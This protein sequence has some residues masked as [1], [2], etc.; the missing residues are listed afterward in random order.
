MAWAVVFLGSAVQA[1]EKYVTPWFQFDMATGWGQVD[2][3]KDLPSV[4][5]PSYSGFQ[6]QIDILFGS[7][8]K[9][10]QQYA[11]EK[12]Q[13]FDSDAP[14]HTVTAQRFFNTNFGYPAHEYYITYK[15][16]RFRYIDVMVEYEGENFL[17]SFWAFIPGTDVNKTSDG[18][19]LSMLNSVRP[20]IEGPKI[21]IHPQSKQ[22]KDGST[23]VLAVSVS[24]EVDYT[25]EWYRNGV[26][27]GRTGRRLQIDDFQQSNAGNYWAVAKNFAGEDRSNTAVV[28]WEA[29]VSAPVFTK[30]PETKQIVKGATLTLQVQVDSAAPHNL[31]WYKDGVLLNSTNPTLTISNV[32]KSNAGRYWAVATNQG[33]KARS[34]IAKIEVLDKAQPPVF[35]AQPSSHEVA[36]G[37]ILTLL[38]AVD[39]NI[40]FTLQWFKDGVPLP[41]NGP[42]LTIENF[43]KEDAGSYWV[44][45]TS[46]SGETVSAIARIEMT[47]GVEA[48]V[49]TSHPQSQ[50]V[51]V[52]DDLNIT[53]EVVSAGPFS[54]QFFKN[55]NPEGS[56]FE[57]NGSTGIR[58]QGTA[59]DDD[60]GSWWAVAKNAAGEVR[61]NIAMITVVSPDPPS[62]TR[63]PQS[64]EVVNGAS[65]TLT[66]EIQ[67]S[68]S[69]SLQWFRNGNPTSNTAATLTIFDAVDDDAGNYWVVAT[70]ASGSVRSGTANV[71][72]RP[73][74]G[75]NNPSEILV[76][77][78][79]EPSFG[80]TQLFGI[81]N[82]GVAAGETATAK[83]SRSAFTFS[84]DGV[85]EQIV[86]QFFQDKQGRA[87]GISDDG[88]TVVGYWTNG[89]SWIYENE[90]QKI[91]QFPVRGISGD[92]NVIVGGTKK[93]DKNKN[94]ALDL[95]PLGFSAASTEARAASFDGKT[96]VG[97]SLKY[98]SNLGEGIRA[99]AWMRGSNRATDL[100]TLGKMS[101][102][103]DVSSDGE[104]VVGSSDG[105]KGKEAFIWKI[106]TGMVG[107][108]DLDG[109]VFFS[110]ATSVSG[111]GLVVTGR[112]YREYG[113]SGFIWTAEEGMRD[114]AD[115]VGQSGYGWRFEW[116]VRDISPNGLYICGNAINPRG[117]S[118]SWIAFDETGKWNTRKSLR[119]NTVRFFQKEGLGLEYYKD[120]DAAHIYLD[121]AEIEG[122]KILEY[123]SFNRG[124]WRQLDYKNS[125]YASSR[126]YK[127]IHIAEPQDAQGSHLFRLK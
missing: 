114:I 24:S 108:G 70:N 55:G 88:K 18:Q 103:S 40:P 36:E 4:F 16:N 29:S 23:L 80:H 124:H 33:G 6:P 41:A 73:L 62:F 89:G 104:T 8:T 74:E 79:H 45:A 42:T 71:T 37:A 17:G 26:S 10:L 112:S 86:G 122:Q 97:Q 93:W 48:P 121:T 106:T 120:W 14:G 107:I 90:G 51:T 83:S 99:V 69:Y 119:P 87:I 52:G 116:G 81:S 101:Q 113:A 31:N 35:I 43:S 125:G 38:V 66:A 11:V 9:T 12:R 50:V 30:Q 76:F 68:I 25:I 2:T 92:G 34:A 15:G 127:F 91:L 102:A 98:Q 64:K 3:G 123:Y 72:I 95:L 59:N 32:T 100:G 49:F 58:L 19:I 67:S 53:V 56:P 96:I 117:E 75:D 1:Q 5:G 109:G 78:S 61:S 60:V 82:T 22:I 27:L 85:T 7:A 21:I 111:D 126:G 44:V 65:F 118:S 47:V 84:I 105:P 110:E 57:E 13:G 94:F 46:Q 54:L 77:A 28:T 39:S 20:V 115:I 63:H